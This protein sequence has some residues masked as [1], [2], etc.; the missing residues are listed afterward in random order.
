[1]P[2]RKNRYVGVKTPIFD[3]PSKVMKL[4]ELNVQCPDVELQQVETE[5]IKFLKTYA[6][7]WVAAQE[8]R[9]SQTRSDTTRD[10][11]SP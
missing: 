10:R 3:A 7:S 6:K 5:F 1:M 8:K 4:I 2:T 11:E 9:A